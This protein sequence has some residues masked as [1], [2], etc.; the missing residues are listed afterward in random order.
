MEAAKTQRTASAERRQLPPHRKEFKC[1]FTTFVCG[2][3]M[4]SQFAHSSPC[5]GNSFQVFM[6]FVWKRGRDGDVLCGDSVPDWEHSSGRVLHWYFSC[7][8]IWYKEPG[9]RAQTGG[10]CQYSR[11]CA[12]SRVM[13]VFTQLLIPNHGRGTQTKESR[14]WR[15]GDSGSAGRGVKEEDVFWRGPWLQDPQLRRR[16]PNK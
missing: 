6:R 8:L 4:H 12:V 14:G 15:G 11:R 2:K 9:L 13:P 5:T 16:K 3:H 7:D 1:H 10:T